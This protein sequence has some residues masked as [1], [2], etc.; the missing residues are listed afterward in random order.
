[1]RNLLEGYFP[2]KIPDLPQSVTAEPRNSSTSSR[3][4]V[5]APSIP[6]CNDSEVERAVR[7][8]GRYDR[9]IHLQDI[10][11]PRHHPPNLK[12]G[13]PPT[14]LANDEVALIVRNGI[15]GVLPRGSTQRVTAMS[16]LRE[17]PSKSRSRLITWPIVANML[18]YSS[19]VSLVDC[20]RLL[21]L[22]YRGDYAATIDLS[23]AFFQHPIPPHALDWYV[24][25]VAG[26]KYF[27]RRLCM[28]SR[29]AVEYIQLILESLTF[30]APSFGVIVNIHVDNILIVG[31]SD[32]VDRYYHLVLD[33][34]ATLNLTVG[35][36]SIGAIIMTH[37]IIFDF[38]HK[39]V[40]IARPQKLLDILGASS[41]FPLRRFFQFLG[42]VQYFARLLPRQCL[43]RPLFFPL[44][45]DLC[46]A[47][48]SFTTGHL[49]LCSPVT[50][51][52]LHSAVRHL[53]S[54]C[55]PVWVPPNRTDV[56][57]ITDA[58]ETGYG[59][60]IYSISTQQFI[61]FAGTLCPP[62]VSEINKKE[63][64]TLLV[65]LHLLT[66]RASTPTIFVRWLGDNMQALL[67]YSNRRSPTALM[68]DLLL[69]IEQAAL[70]RNI[71]LDTLGRN[72]SGVLLNWIPSSKNPA[73]CLS[74][75]PQAEVDLQLLHDLLVEYYI[76]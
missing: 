26:V 3:F 32:N 5:Y 53:L 22:L 59:G 29:A 35:E 70:V 68:N 67:T 20:K 13:I 55:H 19:N 42:R 43:A 61:T 23:C 31:D 62:Y 38:Q 65:A 44:W 36:K 27:Q 28:G 45:S 18:P 34:L 11:F 50:C 74:R 46:V 75:D 72:S 41:P 2:A 57:I 60:I 6:A 14:K 25:K 54:A 8:A 16:F 17:Q 56:V 64:W 33:R 40:S 12:V 48:R 76:L 4:P 49:N 10:L 51:P 71:V 1:M 15:W 52:S 37:G 73:D 30:D 24:I 9:F 66:R 69:H 58:S 7:R 47:C 21:E 63:L 39:T